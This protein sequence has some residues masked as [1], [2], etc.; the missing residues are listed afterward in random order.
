MTEANK[1]GKM[2]SLSSNVPSTQHV[3]TR[4]SERRKS[5]RWEV[6]VPMSLSGSYHS[7]GTIS[8]L[9]TGGCAIHAMSS[10]QKDDEVLLIFALPGAGHVLIRARHGALGEFGPS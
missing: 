4:L 10:Y 2:M 9:S 1:Q 7:E 3:K 5:L 8:N 6:R